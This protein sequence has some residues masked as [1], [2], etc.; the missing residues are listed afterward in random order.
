MS[1]Q[2]ERYF[3]LT[4]VFWDRYR[5]KLRSVSRL[6]GFA[7][8]GLTRRAI[9]HFSLC[10][11][12]RIDGTSPVDYL[13]EPEQQETVRRLSQSILAEQTACWETVLQMVSQELQ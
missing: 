11:L 10:A 1:E 5:D 12:A 4:R 6:D 3:E 9:G 8:D 13:P 7:L 2:R